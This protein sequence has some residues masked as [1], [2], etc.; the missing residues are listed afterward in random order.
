MTL[1]QKDADVY[2]TKQDIWRVNVR[3]F[4]TGKKIKF[5]K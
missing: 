3:D 1:I 5:K 2:N 4:A